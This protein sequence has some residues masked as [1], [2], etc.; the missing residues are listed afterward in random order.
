MSAFDKYGKTAEDGWFTDNEGT[1]YTDKAGFLH[2]GF[3]GWCGCGCP[4]IADLYLLSILEAYVDKE[5]GQWDR[6]PAIFGGENGAMYF[7]LYTLD[8]MGLTEHGSALPG[9]LTNKGRD[10][11]DMLREIRDEL[12]E[13]QP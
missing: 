3:L 8:V 13:A 11:L 12:M 7:A 10:A 5:T 9:W 1:S 2:S 4:E 6:F